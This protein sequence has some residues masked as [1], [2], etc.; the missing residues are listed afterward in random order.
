MPDTSPDYGIDAPEVIRGFFIAGG[1]ASVVS[2]VCFGFGSAML[3]YGRRGKYN[4][5]DKMLSQI[6][7]Q[8]GEAVLDV[9]T[10]RGLLAAGAAK[11]LNTGR[12]VGIDI[13]RAEDL[14]G[15]SLE[16][17]LACLR[18]EGVENKVELK[19]ED[20]RR[21][22]F[23][24]SVFDVVL[25]LLCLHNIEHKAE[26]EAAC[27]EIARV[28]KPGGTVLVGDYVGTASYAKYFAGAG[29]TVKRRSSYVRDAYALM[30]VLE[31]TKPAA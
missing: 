4:V 28:L 25:S 19:D 3:A 27:R 29:L 1:L 11:R 23:E 8:G 20:A 18:L 16:S 6:Q 14:S 30:W 5:R 26:Q 22:S 31:A 12:V 17:T 13:W 24:D 15:N 2:L 9:G 21:L 10:G 7:W